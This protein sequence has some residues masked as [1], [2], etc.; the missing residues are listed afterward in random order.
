VNT[1]SDVQVTGLDLNGMAREFS[2]TQAGKGATLV[3][4]YPEV[5]LR[6]HKSLDALTAALSGHGMATV[7]AQLHDEAEFLVVE[8]S[9]SA[10]KVYREIQRDSLAIG[11]SLFF[12]GVSGSA[13]ER[14]IES[15]I[16]HAHDSLA[17]QHALVHG[18]SPAHG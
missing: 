2:K 15:R 13:A 1:V 14:L 9:V 3:L 18:H 17:T 10:L 8:D 12:D 11:V 6:N 16:P 7:A 4:S 5:D